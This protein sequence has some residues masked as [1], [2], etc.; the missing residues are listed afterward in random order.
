M[1]DYLNNR[2]QRVLIGSVRSYPQK[3]QVGVP[4]GLVLGPMLFKIFIN[5]LFR[6]ELGTEM[7]NLADDNTTIPCGNDA[8]EI[9][10]NLEDDLCKM[11]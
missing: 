5:D 4:Q 9:S 10:V 7:C 1:Y 6:F 3:I 2:C 11:L 8:H